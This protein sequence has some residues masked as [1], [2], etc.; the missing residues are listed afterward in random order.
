MRD[1]NLL[2]VKLELVFVGDG[3]TE[4]LDANL[5]VIEAFSEGCEVDLAVP[6]CV[7]CQTLIFLGMDVKRTPS[8]V[9]MLEDL[10]GGCVA[11]GGVYALE[12][13]VP[14]FV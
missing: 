3:D 4:A 5:V 8:C 1:D 7:V 11:V 9:E 12:L 2:E 13:R 14:V 10:D 6:L